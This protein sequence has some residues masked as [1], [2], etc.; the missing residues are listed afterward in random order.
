MFA[1]SG[2]MPSPSP[3]LTTSLSAPAAAPAP[4]PPP[5][6]PASFP[7]GQ[8]LQ[9]LRAFTQAGTGAAPTA[10]QRAPA[11]SLLQQQ[12]QLHI[13]SAWGDRA[14]AATGG[15]SRAQA[16]RDPVPGVSGALASLKV[17]AAAG[18]DSEGA[19]AGDRQRAFNELSPDGSWVAPQD[20]SRFPIVFGTARAILYHPQNVVTASGRTDLQFVNK[21]A[22]R[23]TVGE[24]LE[25]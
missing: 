25:R 15:Q 8:A 11:R 7:P 22:P 2:G 5:P 9:R 16:S 21:A 3:V 4:P 13:S 23:V 14:Q 12:Q 24:R 10:Q 6:R 19:A 20:D 17:A 1:G 18:A